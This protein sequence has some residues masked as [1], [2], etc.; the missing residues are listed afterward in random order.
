MGEH[1]T[2][3]DI[4]LQPVANGNDAGAA[5]VNRQDCVNGLE[6]GGETEKLLS[7]DCVDSGATRRPTDT[8]Q[9]SDNCVDVPANGGASKTKNVSEDCVDG[10]AVRRIDPEK[11]ALDGPPKEEEKSVV[12]QIKEELNYKV[13]KKVP[14]WAVLVI[15]FITVLLLIFASLTLCRVTYE[16]P[17]EKYD[18]S[19]F[20]A[21]RSFNGSF[22][23][24][25]IESVEK[26]RNMV[27]MLNQP[28]TLELKNMLDDL[29]ES[30]PALG[31]Y[32][33]KS[34]INNFRNGPVTASYTL[35]FKMPSK[36]E[37]ELTHF[38]LSRE[39][40]YNVFKQF[41]YD[42]AVED[43]HRIYI[44]PASLTMSQ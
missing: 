12:D 13:C 25:N 43:S 40:V 36:E 16:D 29:Y 2:S 10:P 9:F 28:L 35:K 24:R 22:E 41:L 7:E 15:I 17:D 20:D 8:K 18:S 21:S 11:D 26:P 32:F 27:S 4:E 23:L 3:I 6:T 42:Q 37:G 38:T 34:E 19:K 1:Q 31:R 39:M 5:Y 33:S 30:S 44:E 14:M